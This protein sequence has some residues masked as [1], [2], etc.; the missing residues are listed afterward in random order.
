MSENTETTAPKRERAKSRKVGAT[1]EVEG[2]GIMLR[3]PDGTVATA[4]RIVTFGKPG[5]YATIATVDGAQVETEY[6]VTAPN[7]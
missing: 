2:A 4:G 7:A 6:V 1:V 5:K 3:H